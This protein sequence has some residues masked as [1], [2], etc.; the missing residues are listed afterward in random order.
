[1]DF[2]L[3]LPKTPRNHNAVWVIVDR[4]I[5]IAHFIPVKVDF[6]FGT[7]NCLTKIGFATYMGYLVA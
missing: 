7:L 6:K 3:G 2:I 5:K 1:M 4:I